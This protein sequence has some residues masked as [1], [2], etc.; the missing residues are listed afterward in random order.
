MFLSL[1]LTLTAPVSLQGTFGVAA[2]IGAAVR[3]RSLSQDEIYDRAYR[4]NRNRFNNFCDVGGATFALFVCSGT[5]LGGYSFLYKP[6]YGHDVPKD[7]YPKRLAR[8]MLAGMW[9]WGPAYLLALYLG[10]FVRPILERQKGDGMT[11]EER[12]NA[13]FIDSLV[14]GHSSGFHSNSDEDDS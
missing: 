5:T 3:M 7:I 9:A 6:H 2:A 13:E 10:K 12:Y 4:L 8:G 14:E 1:S 11:D